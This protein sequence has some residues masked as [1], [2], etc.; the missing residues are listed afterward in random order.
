MQ[1]WVRVR[2]PKDKPY[3]QRMIETLL[4]ECLDYLTGTLSVS[5]LQAEIDKWLKKYHS[6]RPHE[7]QV[8]LTPAEFLTNFNSH[9]CADNTVP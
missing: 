8:F 2:A 1:L 9:S 4:T 5:E 6:Y 7:S 3:I